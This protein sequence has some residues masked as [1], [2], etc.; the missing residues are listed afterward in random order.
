MVTELVSDERMI[1]KI[2]TIQKDFYRE[3]DAVLTRLE[4]E[5]DL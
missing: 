1:E 3:H 5:L 4:S 2:D